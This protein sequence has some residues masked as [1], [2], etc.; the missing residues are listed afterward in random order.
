MDDQISIIMEES[1]SVIS[2]DAKASVL[3]KE[4]TFLVVRNPSGLRCLRFTMKGVTDRQAHDLVWSDS[5]HPCLRRLDLVHMAAMAIVGIDSIVHL[6]LR[7]ELGLMRYYHLRGTLVF[8]RLPL[9][10]AFFSLR[11]EVCSI[12]LIFV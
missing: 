8:S 3:M 5:T 9:C 6:V 2:D 10:T 4:F 12:V 1:R 11:R 7:M